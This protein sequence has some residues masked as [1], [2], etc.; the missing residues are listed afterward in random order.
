M[1]LEQAVKE[2]LKQ[3]GNEPEEINIRTFSTPAK[4]N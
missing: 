3:I 4:G 2:L 1:Q